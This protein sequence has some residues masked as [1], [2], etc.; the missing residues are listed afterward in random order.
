MIGCVFPLSL[1]ADKKPE[2]R[3]HSM[4]FTARHIEPNGIGYDQGYTTLE[5]FFSPPEPWKGVWFPF[6]DA[7]GHLFNDGKW[8]A[9]GG[10]GLRYLKCSR[11]WGATA[12]YDYRDTKHG[13]FNQAALGLEALGEVWDFRINGYLP[14]GSKVSKA[15]NTKFSRFQGNQVLLL[16]RQQLL[17][18][19]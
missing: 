3:P 8:A 11:I 2:I 9:N 12:Y 6:L 10:L 4:R 1:W 13:P 14:F 15:Y 18:P 17:W 19:G 5:G 7:R 16:Q